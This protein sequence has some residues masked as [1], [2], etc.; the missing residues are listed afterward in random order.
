[1]DNS[2][3]IEYHLSRRQILA[4]AA[5]LTAGALW[6]GARPANAASLLLPDPSANGIARGQIFDNQIPD[7]S[8]YAG[9]VDFVWGAS[10][11]TQP[12]GA[13]P[14]GYL[15]A[16]RDF[17]RTHT[18][19]WYQANHPDWVVYQADRV[20]PAWEFGNTLYVPIDI[21]NAAVRTY[22]FSTFVQPLIDQGY[23]IIGFDNVAT[24]NVYNSA[25][26][27][28]ADGAW[29][30]QYDGRDD[31][32]WPAAVLGWLGYLAGQLHAR[33]V[34][35][36]AN[37]TW[38]ASVVLSDIQQAVGLVDI[39]VDEQGFTVHR[40]SNYND[41]AWR[42]KFDFARSVAPGKLYLAINQTTAADLADASQ[43]QV[44]WAIA[45]Y[46][47]Y[48]E[49]LSMMTLCGVGQY[50]VFV[51][52]P[53]LHTDIGTPSSAP[54]QDTTGGWKRGYTGGRVLVNPSS[55]QAV[56]MVLPAGTWTDLHG[57]T[58]SGHITLPPNSGTVLST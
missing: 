24:P 34:A 32:A 28:D 6:P 55:T 20:T 1:M 25:G 38:N 3:R 50:H 15:P 36:A 33:D 51:D 13:V 11:L 29:V 22:Y 35:M 53:E 21:T 39:Y 46:L 40:D 52:H 45:N 30:Q 9:L 27:Y 49:R 14:S 5:A 17:D 7:R 48:R 4:G 31:R 37:I 8:V 43:A 57:A 16:F 23:P 18:L 54:V 42:D 12:A 19:A 10:T 2:S 47:L 58:H 41:Q 56:T 26:H 44:D